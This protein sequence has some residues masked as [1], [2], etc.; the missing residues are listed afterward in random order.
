MPPASAASRSLLAAVDTS[1]YSTEGPVAMKNALWIFVALPLACTLGLLPRL[2]AA[3]Q[4]GPIVYLVRGLEDEDLAVVGAALAGRDD[5]VLLLDSD[6]SS[7]HLARFITSIHSRQLIALGNFPNA[8]S[9]LPCR[10]GLCPDR[11]LPWNLETAEELWQKHLPDSRALVVCAAG[12]RRILLQAAALAGS[13]KA[14]LFVLRGGEG[15]RTLLRRRLDR[16]DKVYVVGEVEGLVPKSGGIRK[17]VLR[18]EEAVAVAHRNV[19][20]RGGDIE[21]AVICNPEDAREGQNRLSSLAPWVAAQK[22]A[23]LLLTGPSG[24]DVPAIVQRAVEHESLRRL[25]ALLLLAD[26]QA[27]PW[28]RRPNPIAGKDEQI[29]MEPLTPKESEPYSFAIG[30]LFHSDLGVVPLTLARQQW[31]TSQPGPRRALIA[32]NA[33]GGLVLLETISRGTAAEFSNAGYETTARFGRD[34]HAD[35]LRRLLPEQLLFLWEGHH[36]VLM[37]EFEFLTWD[38]PLQPGLVFLQSCLA[39]AEPKVQPVL[40]RGAVAVIGTSTRTY[41]GSG[42][43]CS[44]AFFDALLYDGRSVGG[45]LRQAKNFLQACTLLKEKR[46]GKD[47]AHKG[48]T[49]RAAWAFTLWGDPTLHFPSPRP[50][51]EARPTVDHKVRGNTLTLLVPKETADPVKTEKYQ[52]A[53]PANGRLAGLVRKDLV[54]GK[55]EDCRELAPL[56]FAEVALPKARQGTVPH[57]TSR[58]PSS[59]WVFAWDARR[60][61]GYVLLLPRPQDK[62]EVQFRIHWDTPETAR[63]VPSTSDK[64]K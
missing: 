41:S 43:A 6:L 18:D 55:D 44:R 26:L 57:L 34:V 40:S 50:P 33:G 45:S 29:E 14:P 58:V 52:A 36:G 63:D 17:V 31:Q 28:E 8:S 32:G 2:G 13:A 23:A 37:R 61:T 49:V 59:H 53:L 5:A 10:L 3:P 22:R 35:E 11:F 47:A 56:V 54:T 60:H 51:A 19:L 25:D 4:T 42:G 15:E 24:A 46:L 20:L 1:R 48:A 21:T 12:Q 30:R 16:A 9:D 38:E 64:K 39:L 62:G 27:I 7:P